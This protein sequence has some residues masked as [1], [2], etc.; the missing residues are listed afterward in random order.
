MPTKICV[1]ATSPAAGKSLVMPIFLK[2]AGSTNGMPVGPKLSLN[3]DSSGTTR[4][5]MSGGGSNGAPVWMPVPVSEMTVDA[6][7]ASELCTACIFDTGR[8]CTYTGTRRGLGD[9]TPVSRKTWPEAS[10]T[11]EPSE[12]GVTE[13]SR[14]R[15]IE[16]ATAVMVTTTVPAP[17]A[18]TTRLTGV[19]AKVT[20][21]ATTLLL[22]LTV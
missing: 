7:K 16:A 8:A 5:V 3:C 21:G 15:S 20:P 19:T 2:I 17:W 6:P 14:L 22:K 18:G 10:P 9:V 12:A 13:G 1:I 11:H 4:E